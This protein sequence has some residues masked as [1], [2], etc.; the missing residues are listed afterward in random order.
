[1][2]AAAALFGALIGSFLNVVTYR[3]P[4]RESLAF[5]PSRCP[6]CEHP[7]RPWHNVPVVNGQEQ[8]PGA[9]YRAE[10]LVA[11]ANSLALQLAA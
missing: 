2:T 8:R 4:R 9:Q 7:I 6:D 11:S 3:L 5:P 1:M 10:D